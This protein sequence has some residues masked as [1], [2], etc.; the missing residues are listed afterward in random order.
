[1]TEPQT[2]K[3]HVRWYPIV[4]FV[5]FPLTIINVIWQI[6]MLWQGPGWNQAESLLMAI[7]L[8]LIV[9]T[10][11]TQ[12][13]KAQDRVIRLE[14]YLRYRGVLPPDLAEKACAFPTGRI[15][16]LRFAHDDELAEIVQRIVNGEFATNKELK[17]AIKNWR[18][19]YL[20]V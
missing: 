10:A 14:E 3:N 16:A 20:R 5:I 1:M 6:V 4:H 8:V 15:I 13:L 19:D 18:G 7:V 2:F 11:R 12:S 17:L 9:F